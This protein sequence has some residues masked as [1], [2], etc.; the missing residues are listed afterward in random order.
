MKKLLFLLLFIPAISCYSQNVIDGIG[1]IKLGCDPSILSELGYSNSPIE[2]EYLSS[3]FFS[4]VYEKY[5]GTDCYL[6]TP[7]K[8]DPTTENLKEYYIPTYDPINSVNLKGITLSFYNDY[9]YKIKINKEDGL[10]EAFDEKYGKHELKSEAKEKHY[11]NGL[12]N[13]ITKLDE[14]FRSTWNTG[15]ENIICIDH[16]S[17]YHN[18]K[19]ERTIISYFMIY[20]NQISEK[21]SEENKIIKS[22]KEELEKKEKLKDLDLL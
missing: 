7:S 17:S 5:V 11:V 13:K 1:K 16:L 3:I 21:V 6:I 20:D 10:S 12:G 19:G 22:K 2:V 15:N 14:T 9:L 4:K 8:E 18:H